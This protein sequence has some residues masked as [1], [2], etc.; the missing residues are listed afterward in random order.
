MRLSRFHRVA[1]SFAAACLVVVA[2]GQML[3]EARATTSSGDRNTYVPITPNRIFDTR[4]SLHFT[5]GEIRTLQVTGT[6]GVPMDAT[7][8]VLNV[9]VTNP[10]LPGHLTVWPADAA[11]PLAS[12]LNFAPGETIPNAVTTKLSPGGAFKIENIGGNTDVIV[13]VNGFYQLNRPGI[14]GDS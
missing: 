11:K 14:R 5:A 2:A 12:S 1:R 7:A 9:T 3:P 10:T 4:P 13:D 6:T 8:A